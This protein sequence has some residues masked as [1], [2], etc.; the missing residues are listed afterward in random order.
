MCNRVFLQHPVL[1]FKA[2]G[3]MHSTHGATRSCRPT[4]ARLVVSFAVPD[5]PFAGNRGAFPELR[6]RWS[7]HSPTLAPQRRAAGMGGRK[8]WSTRIRAEVEGPGR[9]SR[10]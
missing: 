8:W 9:G 7:G 5:S 4:R 6:V 1:R 10:S 3:A 2:R